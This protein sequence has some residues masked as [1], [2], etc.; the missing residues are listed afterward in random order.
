MN[1]KFFT[2]QKRFNQGD[3]EFEGN[4][5]VQNLQKDVEGLK[6]VMTEN[7]GRNFSYILNNERV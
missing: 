2:Y 6:S 7:I 5:K 3:G 4:N 1:Y